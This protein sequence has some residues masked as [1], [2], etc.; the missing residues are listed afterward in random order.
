MATATLDPGSVLE[1][2]LLY[3]SGDW[4]LAA[5]DRGARAGDRLDATLNA[6]WLGPVGGS[7]ERPMRPRRP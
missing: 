4:D 1:R 3:W 7:S 6:Y 2:L 5:R